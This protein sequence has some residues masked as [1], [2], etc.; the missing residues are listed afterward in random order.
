MQ[1]WGESSATISGS[2]TTPI[3][4]AEV[5]TPCPDEMAATGERMLTMR[6]VPFTAK[7]EQLSLE[8]TT[9]R[10]TAID[11]FGTRTCWAERV[12]DRS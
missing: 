9:R 10:N 6:G 7:T 11:P 8:A 5:R 3:T 12:M 4:M 1:S 2:C